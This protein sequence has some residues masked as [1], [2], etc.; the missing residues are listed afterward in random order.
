MSWINE[1][2]YLI[3]KY[4][5]RESDD[6]DCEHINSPKRLYILC[7][8]ILNEN[9]YPFIQFMLE[10]G[11]DIDAKTSLHL[12]FIEITSNT[13][14]DIHKLIVSK[15]G[16]YLHSSIDNIWSIKN[17]VY[18]GLIN[19]SAERLYALVDISN[20]DIRNMHYVETNQKGNQSRIV[21]ALP[22]EI[23]NFG[24]IYNVKVHETVKELFYDLPELG[25]L[26]DKHNKKP[27]PLPDAVY[28]GS[29]FD[30]VVHSSIFGPSRKFINETGRS[31]FYFNT[32][33][34]DAFLDG[35][36]ANDVFYTPKDVVDRNSRFKKY[37][38]GG[39]TRYALFP[40]SFTMV[41][42]DDD[43]IVFSSDLLD[44]LDTS[45][46]LYVVRR[47]IDDV[48][49]LIL[50][51]DY[52]SFVPLSYCEIDMKSLGDKYDVNN[53]RLYRLS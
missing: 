43:E 6:I 18:K 51:R 28:S 35:G 15:I 26:H 20:V 46:Q 16:L 36:W 9:K 47:L 10:K 4:A 2:I 45:K 39:I 29:F 14:D 25:V 11:L 37:I 52:D 21:F 3:E 44:T 50:V 27:Y 17:I 40:E 1:Y 34:E 7:Y 8:H 19:D 5:V 41:E 38:R 42:A 24:Y 53:V 22:S 32:E 31:C 48:K 49:V 23:I 12:P 13:H 30:N 33:F